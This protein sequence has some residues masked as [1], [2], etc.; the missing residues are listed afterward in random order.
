MWN[1][2]IYMKPRLYEHFC[3]YIFA[4]TPLGNVATD[5]SV[6]PD[7]IKEEREKKI[8]WVQGTPPAVETAAFAF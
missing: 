8:I 6:S 7:A 2:Y 1:L 5:A 3:I 4:Q